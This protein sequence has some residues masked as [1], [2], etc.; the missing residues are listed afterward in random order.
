MIFDGAVEL[1]EFGGRLAE[2]FTPRLARLLGGALLVP[3]FAFGVLVL[4]S[5]DPE[6]EETLIA[7]GRLRA[8]LGGVTL[9]LEEAWEMR[10]CSY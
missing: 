10:A 6:S 1:E 2:S 3:L 9:A 5:S 7:R 8:E 4:S